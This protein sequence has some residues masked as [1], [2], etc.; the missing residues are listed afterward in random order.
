MRQRRYD[1]TPTAFHGRYVPPGWQVVIVPVAPQVSHE[2]SVVPSSLAGVM[3]IH[4][5]QLQSFNELRQAHATHIPFIGLAPLLT[6]ILDHDPVGRMPPDKMSW[7]SQERKE[8]IPQQIETLMQV[9]SFET[10]TKFI[11]NVDTGAAPNTGIGHQPVR[12]SH[13]RLDE[14]FDDK[15]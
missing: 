14:V 1:E 7:L 3:N 12:L 11:G 15:A 8:V 4:N 10:D 9:C 13:V 6:G 5:G 2:D